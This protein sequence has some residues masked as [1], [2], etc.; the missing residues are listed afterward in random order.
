MVTC[1]T[2][3]CD[4]LVEV[5]KCESCWERRHEDVIYDDLTIMDE[6]IIL[7]QIEENEW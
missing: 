1:E 4:N 7:Q 5:G 2:L 6:Q 3:H